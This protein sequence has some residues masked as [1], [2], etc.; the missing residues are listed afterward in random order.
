MKKDLKVKIIDVFG[1]VSSLAAIFFFF[2][3]W[4][5]SYNSVDQPFKEAWSSSISFLS[6]LATFAA[7]YIAAALVTDW[8]KQTTY[9]SQ[10]II[11]AEILNDIQLLKEEFD[12][13]RNDDQMFDYLK[14][15]LEKENRNINFV[16]LDFRVLNNLVNNIRVKYF[17]LKMLSSKFDLFPLKESN[18]NIFLEVQAEL[19]KFEI[20]AK[21]INVFESLNFFYDENLERAFYISDKLYMVIGYKY[22]HIDMDN[23]SKIYDKFNSLRDAITDYKNLIDV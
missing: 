6:V 19:K 9:S 3:L 18:T 15:I 22:T 12:R 17:Q 10:V 14:N 11:L 1:V 8:K 7:A 13:I 4:L 2:T 16:P 23:I 21:N 20:R 5:F